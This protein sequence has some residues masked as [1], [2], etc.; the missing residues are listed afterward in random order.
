MM[1]LLLAIIPLGFSMIAAY[2]FYKGQVPGELVVAWAW[3]AGVQTVFGFY[4]LQIQ[5]LI[6]QV[7]RI[8]G[9]K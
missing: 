9:V 7:N 1:L 6:E 5:G 4:V 8:V 2:R 3:C